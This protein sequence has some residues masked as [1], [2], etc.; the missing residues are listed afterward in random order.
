LK[1]YILIAFLIRL[2]VHSSIAQEPTI[3]WQR[4][5]GGTGNEFDLISAENFQGDIFI[6]GKTYSSNNGDIPLNN[7]GSDI[8]IAKLN[9]AG[10]TIWSKNYGGNLDD[11]PAS[12]TPTTDGGVVIL[13]YSASTSGLFNE[14]GVW[15]LKLN[16]AGSEV[17]KIF[18]GGNPDLKGSVIQTTDGGF[19]FLSTKTVASNALNFWVVKTNSAGV[20][21]W[22]NTYGGPSNEYAADIIELNNFYYLL[23]ESES[24]VVNS[25]ATNGLSDL[26]FIK[27]NSIGTTQWT[28]LLGGPGYDEG[29]GVV[30]DENNKFIILGNKQGIGSNSDIWIINM[31]AV[32]D[33]PSTDYTIGKTKNE[34]AK[35]I[36][37]LESSYTAVIV[38]E[39]YSDWFETQE[40]DTSNILLAEL[41]LYGGTPTPLILGG[42]GYDSP[43]S[44]TS[45]IDG[46][47]LVSGHSFST[48]GNFNNKGGSDF[49]IAKLAYPCPNELS[50]DAA[51]F[52]KSIS[53]K[54]G[55][56]ITTNSTFTGPN[57][58][59]KLRS[60]YIILEEGFSV[61]PGTVFETEIGGCQN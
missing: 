58:K 54:A 1:K 47:L 28:K 12:I 4:N 23:G 29:I 39:N 14:A 40:P 27:I 7:G 38:A 34:F 15:L 18:Y 16:N 31:D 56:F 32:G 22:Q 20:L 8:Y 30:L 3:S 45:T 9:S 35:D 52:T 57:T 33:F 44:I 41:I 61:E 11:L 6:A 37:F 36:F 13:C 46:G 50:L 17:F 24:S 21:T 53:R 25:Q 10:T 51:T 55:N 60:N 5:I 48:L 42:N 19:I 59:V 43:T 2:M 49:W 26:L